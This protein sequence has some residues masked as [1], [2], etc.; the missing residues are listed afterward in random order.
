MSASDNDEYPTECT[1]ENPCP[2]HGGKA[3]GARFRRVFFGGSV[4]DYLIREMADPGSPEF[5][6]RSHDERSQ[7]AR[8]IALMALT[9]YRPGTP[10]EGAALRAWLEEG[11]EAS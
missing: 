1:P 9:G 7:R 8:S 6:G 3:D 4:E 5:E 10:E 2:A 11:G